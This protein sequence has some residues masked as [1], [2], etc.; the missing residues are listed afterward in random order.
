MSLPFSWLRLSQVRNHMKRPASITWL[1]FGVLHVFI[2]EKIEIINIERY[3]EFGINGFP[4]AGHVVRMGK[5]K[6]AYRILVT[7]PEGKFQDYAYFF[8]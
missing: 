3:F 1:T 2:S 5:K 7:K 4:T 6:N 8:P